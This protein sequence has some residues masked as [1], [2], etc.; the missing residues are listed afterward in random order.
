MSLVLV[1]SIDDLFLIGSEPLIIE[2][3][4]ELTFEFEM[5][6]L[7]LMNYFLGLEVWKTPGK[8]FLSQGK[9]VVKLLEIF[10]MTE[11]KYMA[12]QIEINFNKLCG[13]DARPD[14]VNPSE[15]R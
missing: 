15:Y 13:E 3:K 1:L 11:C 7:G 5:K 4:R 9:Y 6:N 14:L 12:T 10:G 8:I 2:C